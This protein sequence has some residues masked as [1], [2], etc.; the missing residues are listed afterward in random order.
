MGNFRTNDRP[1][2]NRGSGR[3][4]GSRFSGRSS[5]GFGDRDRGDRG[6]GRGRGFEDR[7]ARRPLEMNDVTCDKCGKECQV[8]FR[9][10]GGKPVYCSDCFRA[11]GNAPDSGSRNN[12][13]RNDRQSPSGQLQSGIS[14]QQFNQ[15][16]EKVDKMLAILESLE[17]IEDDE[18]LG[19]DLDDEDTDE[20]VKEELEDD[21]DEE[22]EGEDEDLEEETG[23][24]SKKK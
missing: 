15:L 7:G 3:S 2:Y 23:K 24:N 17:V 22:E 21:A 13:L 10:T 1:E 14:A 12:F 8:P 16:N 18:E 19:E 11:S 5:R 6:R 9:P 4:G 20:K